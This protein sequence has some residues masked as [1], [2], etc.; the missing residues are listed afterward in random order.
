M[1]IAFYRWNFH[2]WHSMQPIHL[3]REGSIVIYKKKTW[4][5]PKY[6][7]WKKS[8]DPFFGITMRNCDLWD[9]LMIP[10]HDFSII[11]KKPVCRHDIEAGKKLDVLSWWYWKHMICHIRTR[12][13]LERERE[14]SYKPVW[15]R[16]EWLEQSAL[17]LH[18]RF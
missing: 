11:R 4:Q 17:F 1:D 16:L 12:T 5:I 3:G 15:L 2:A 9:K 7:R 6:N 10:F 18:S 14:D 13:I 8:Q